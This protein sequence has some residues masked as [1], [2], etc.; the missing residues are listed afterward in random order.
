MK[1]IIVSATSDIATNICLHWKKKKWDLFGTY[2]SQAE[3]YE[4]LSKE[5]IPLVFCNL[6]DSASTDAAGKILLESARDWDFIL[7]A[8]GSQ[9]PVGL[10]E[11]VD[12][13]SWVNSIHINFLNQMRLLH[14]LLPGRNL[15]SKEKSVIFFA[16]GGTNNAVNYYSAYTLSK[17]SL[18]KACELLDSEI[19]DVK[20]SIIGPGWVKTKIHDATLQSG[21]ERAGKN[22]EKT[23]QKLS[24]D[25]C[26]PISQVIKSIDWTLSQPK[27]IVGGRN[28]STVFDKW[29]TDELVQLLSQDENM[30]KLRRFK[31]D[32]LV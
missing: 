30:Y 24:S 14:H 26:V 15:Y 1:G 17:I 19:A 28:L 22:F 20:F 3:N 29:G 27:K 31:N 4:T 13:N 16:G 11:K 10:F 32:I 18:I 2:L 5:Q 8:T 23:K 9:I 7:F 12:I 6:A 25:D 21:E